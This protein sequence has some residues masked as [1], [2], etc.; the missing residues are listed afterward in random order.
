MVNVT[1]YDPRMG[2]KRDIKVVAAVVAHDDPTTG[3]AVMLQINQAIHAPTIE[4]NLLCPMQLRLNDVGVDE[5]PK[6]L[7]RNA[8]D[9]T[10][11]IV[12]DEGKSQECLIPLSLRGVTSY[13]PTRKPSQQEHES[14]TGS[15]H[16]LTA[17]E[18]EWNPH[19]SDYEGQESAL[20]GM[21]G[22]LKDEPLRQP[23]ALLPVVTVTP[24]DY[25]LASV[26]TTL[27][28]GVFAL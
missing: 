12:T 3:E 15:V 5:C 18:P 28:D 21:D 2:S 20:V 26:N 23:N 24:E 11:A 9:K 22:R 25:T 17:E 1:G 4:A 13:F 7:A 19:A 10:H 27:D 16:E 8:T 14:H 6:F